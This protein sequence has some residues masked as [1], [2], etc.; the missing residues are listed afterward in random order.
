MT[1]NDSP[2]KEMLEQE[3]PLALAFFYPKVHADLDWTRDH[4]SLDQELRKLDPGGAIGKRIV[5][6]LV[7]AWSK[8]GDARFLHVEVQGKRQRHLPKRMND[9]NVRCEQ[10]FGSK[11]LVQYRLA[12]G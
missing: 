6:R 8:G 7:K 3:L 4:E 10:H 1:D 11:R 2:W 12:A 9:Y 5:D